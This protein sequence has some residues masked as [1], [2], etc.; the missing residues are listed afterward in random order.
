MTGEERAC[1]FSHTEG[2]TESNSRQG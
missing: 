2:Y 1:D